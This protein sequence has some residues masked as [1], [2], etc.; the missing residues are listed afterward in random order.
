MSH[1]SSI[2]YHGRRW[3]HLDPAHL[4]ESNDGRELDADLSKNEA[5]CRDCRNRVTVGSEEWGHETDCEHYCWAD[6]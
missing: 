6:Q 2:G 1:Q 4:V 5:W 3:P